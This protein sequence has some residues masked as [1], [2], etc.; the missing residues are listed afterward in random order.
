MR[1]LAETAV[2]CPFCGKSFCKDSLES[3]YATDRL[4]L[5]CGHRW[6]SRSKNAPRRC[7]A[8]RSKEWNVSTREEVL[9]G[10]CGHR[11]V[12]RGGCLPEKCPKCKSPNWNGSLSVPKT[13]EN[14]DIL[15]A[16]TLY[17]EGMGCVEISMTTGIPLEAVAKKVLLRTDGSVRMSSKRRD[18]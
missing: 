3:I 9:C 12:P 13:F 8:C 10:K 1:K 17:S 2:T 14:Q 15:H 7:P 4:C 18:A 6:L 5:V 16:L 11:W